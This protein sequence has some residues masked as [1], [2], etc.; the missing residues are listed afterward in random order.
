MRNE[1]RIVSRE[2]K[3]RQSELSG[4]PLTVFLFLKRCG[5]LRDL[6]EKPNVSRETMQENVKG[7]PLFH[8][9]LNLRRKAAGLVLRMFQLH[10]HRPREVGLMFRLV[11][12]AICKSARGSADSQAAKTRVFS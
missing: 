5:S 6:H 11:H 2:T 10:Q 1:L 8:A 3:H 7:S 12:S 4:S 9:R